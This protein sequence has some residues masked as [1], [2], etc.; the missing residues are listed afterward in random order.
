M[1]NKEKYAKKIIEIACDGDSIAIASNSGKL[2]R[3][4]NIKCC[5]CLFDF[6]NCENDTREWAESEYIEK[7]VISKRDRAFLDYIKEGC[8]FVARDENGKLFVYGSKPYKDKRCNCW[9]SDRRNS[10]ILCLN[11]N[12]VFP[13]VKWEDS[14]PWLIEDLKK[15]EVVEEYE[16][17][18]T[19]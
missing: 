16:Q 1:K 17:R 19:F 18:N 11:Y 2:V 7:P 4:R 6:A 9:R 3:C 5:E 14:E 15:L 10:P 13:M 12:I 8:K